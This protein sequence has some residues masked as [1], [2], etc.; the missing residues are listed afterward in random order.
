MGK[1]AIILYTTTV[2]LSRPK[3]AFGEG[4]TGSGF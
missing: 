4:L 1:I 3:V 2:R